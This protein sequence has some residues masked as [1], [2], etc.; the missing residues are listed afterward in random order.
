MLGARRRRDA[1]QKLY[2]RLPQKFQ[3]KKVLIRAVIA[4]NLVLTTKRRAGAVPGKF[5]DETRE[6][7]R[8]Y[9]TRPCIFGCRD[10]Q[11]KMR[12]RGR[13]DRRSI[14]RQSTDIGTARRRN[15]QSTFAETLT[16]F[17]RRY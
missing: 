3:R 4:V 5:S 6:P 17:S 9:F 15:W 7:R 16:L 1:A 10:D 12:G 2:R 8:K 13:L 14:S 11:N